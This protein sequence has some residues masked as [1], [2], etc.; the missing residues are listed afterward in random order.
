MTYLTMRGI[1]WVDRAGYRV[2]NESCPKGKWNEADKCTDV[3]EGNN[4]SQTFW[5]SEGCQYN[6]LLHSR[7]ASTDTSSVDFLRRSRPFNPALT[8]AG[9][10][11]GIKTIVE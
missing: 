3:H 4:D 2:D 10:K 6:P 5:T 11:R 1:F 7:H 9:P 8:K